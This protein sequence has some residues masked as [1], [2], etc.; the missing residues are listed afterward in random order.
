VSPLASAARLNKR[1]QQ[2]GTENLLRKS[3]L[4]KR[5]Q[6]GEAL[7]VGDRGL[8]AAVN[9]SNFERIDEKDAGYVVAVIPGGGYRAQYKNGDGTFFDEPV[10]AW[11][12][13]SLGYFSPVTI[14]SDGLD[15]NPQHSG[16]FVGIIRPDETCD[17]G[18][19]IDD[20]EPG[21]SK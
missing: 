15:D 5:S 1:Y 12:I 8:R 21:G 14:G 4:T 17:Q 10:L 11:K 7:V 6:D 9:Y 20:C 16:N 19:L 2:S 3:Q 18:K 13:C